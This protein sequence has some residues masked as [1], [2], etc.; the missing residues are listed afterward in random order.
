[1]NHFIWLKSQVLTFSRVFH[2][3]LLPAMPEVECQTE[4]A[5]KTIEGMEQHCAIHQILIT[6]NW[7]GKPGINED[8]I[9][10]P[11]GCGLTKDDTERFLFR[12][13]YALEGMELSV[14]D[15]KAIKHEFESGDESSEHPHW[16]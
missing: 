1:M 3:L 10:L 13:F 16:R 4:M 8:S 12:S 6:N 2:S 11:F 5:L 9:A 14:S 15:F 7:T